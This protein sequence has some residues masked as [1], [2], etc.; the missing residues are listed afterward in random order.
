M[1]DLKEDFRG[2]AG[3]ARL[4]IIKDYVGWPAISAGAFALAQLALRGRIDQPAQS[5]IGR[6]LRK[7][8]T[9]G[10]IGATATLLDRLLPG[11][12]STFLRT[13]AADALANL[14]RNVWAHAIIF[15][16]HFPESPTRPTHSVK[17][18]WRT[19]PAAVGTSAS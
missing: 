5:R 1:A 12:E 9:K 11:V 6:R 3:K 17:S 15:C 4:Q 8:S 16:G 19:K 13:L 18:K 10:R 2:I 7:I 14:I